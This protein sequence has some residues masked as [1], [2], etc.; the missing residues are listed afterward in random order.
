MNPL[1]DRLLLGTA[2]DASPLTHVEVLPERAGRVA[3]WPAWTPDALRERLAARGVIAP[4]EHQAAAAA[5]AHA[6]VSVIV[7][8]GTASGKSLAYQLP[9]LA[10]DRAAR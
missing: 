5:M 8:T 9:G 7:A 4:W 2:P 3:A 6:G 10:A 1:L